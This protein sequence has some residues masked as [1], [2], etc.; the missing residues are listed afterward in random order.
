MILVQLR[1]LFQHKTLDRG[2]RSV[3]RKAIVFTI[4]YPPKKVPKAIAD[5]AASITGTGMAKDLDCNIPPAINNAVIIPI[6]F[7]TSFAP[8]VREKNADE[9]IWNL[10]NILLTFEGLA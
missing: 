8:W 3:N 10:P 2:L 9:A 6:V 4:L 5:A 1:L 7:C